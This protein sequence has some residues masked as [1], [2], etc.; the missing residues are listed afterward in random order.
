MVNGKPRSAEQVGYLTGVILSTNLARVH[1]SSLGSKK[2]TKY[3]AEIICGVDKM[4]I[5]MHVETNQRCSIAAV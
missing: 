3:C 1:A 4:L 2:R 5:V